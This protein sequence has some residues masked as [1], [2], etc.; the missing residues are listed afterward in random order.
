M[1]KIRFYCK[2]KVGVSYEGNVIC[3]HLKRVDVICR[4]RLKCFSF[5]PSFWVPL[6]LP[7]TE[8]FSE[9]IFAEVFV[10]CICVLVFFLISFLVEALTFIGFLA[11]VLLDFI[12][13]CFSKIFWEICCD[14][15]SL[16]SFSLS[17]MTLQATAK[18]SRYTTSS[19]VIFRMIWGR[20]LESLSIWPIRKYLPQSISRLTSI[21]S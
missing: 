5:F 13:W 16:T 2:I 17:I 4:C 8:W 1:I 18:F 9:P 12:T 20:S 10:L 11:T 14:T 19:T 3:T 15:L 6:L 7:C 21:S